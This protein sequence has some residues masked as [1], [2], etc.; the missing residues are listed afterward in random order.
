MYMHVYLQFYMVTCTNGVSSNLPAH[1]VTYVC[2]LL[3]L[4]KESDLDY[5]AWLIPTIVVVVTVVAAVV[6]VTVMKYAKAS[7]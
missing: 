1:P 2:I 3:L 7:R 4:L 6:V 5:I